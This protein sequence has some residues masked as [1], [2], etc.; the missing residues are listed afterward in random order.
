VRA[1][2]RICIDI[3]DPKL[4]EIPDNELITAALLRLRQ[5]ELV[6]RGTLRLDRLA[7]DLTM[8]Q[9]RALMLVRLDGPYAIGELSRVLG[10]SQPSCS[11]LVDRLEERGL[12]ARQDDPGDRRVTL[13]GV[14]RAGAELV[15]DLWHFREDLVEESLRMMDPTDVEALSLGLTALIAAA[16]V[17]GSSDHG[18]IPEKAV[19]DHRSMNP[20]FWRRS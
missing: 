3:E 6:I 16:Q 2:W 18:A 14:T 10:V 15:D 11:Q 5:A 8:T 13:V 12:V 20:K 7:V 1:H 17:V 4:D 9:L 19:L